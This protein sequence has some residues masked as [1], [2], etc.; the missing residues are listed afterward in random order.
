MHKSLSFEKYLQRKEGISPIKKRIYF[1]LNRAVRKL[2]KL[3]YEKSSI[4]KLN[5]FYQEVEQAP[6]LGR[7]DWLFNQIHKVK[8]GRLNKQIHS[9]KRAVKDQLNLLQ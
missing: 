9:P 5:V 6:E 3:I 1:N 8:L 7:K 4:L 2:A